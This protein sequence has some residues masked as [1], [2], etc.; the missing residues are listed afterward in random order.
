MIMHDTDVAA[1]KKAETICL[2]GFQ[3]SGHH[4]RAAEGVPPTVNL[5]MAVQAKHSRGAVGICAWAPP[6]QYHHYL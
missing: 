4:V 6:A 5:P 1:Q 3:Y 2:D